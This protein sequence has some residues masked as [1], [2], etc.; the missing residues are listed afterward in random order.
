MKRIS[1]GLYV[2]LFLFAASSAHA[3][4]L[5]CIFIDG[6]ENLGTTNAEDLASVERSNCARATV[7]PPASTPLPPLTW[8]PTIASFA[9]NY[10]AQCTWAHNPNRG[11]YGE[12]IFASYTSGSGVASMTD[13]VNDW[14]AEE[15]Y[16]DIA[17]NTCNTAN[18][19]NEA[20]TCGHYTQLVWA[21]TTT[22]GC[23]KTY[24]TTGS[25]FKGAPTPNWTFVVC[26]YNPE[27]NFNGNRPYTPA[28]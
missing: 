17:D 4:F 11:S 8:D 20:Q 6:L 28:D 26:D 1:S 3:T 14:A 21:D 23:G 5:D 25:P 24:C 2:L 15:Q 18:P 12:N 13:A 10:S 16:Y 7:T 19:P 27:G 22:V 9:Q